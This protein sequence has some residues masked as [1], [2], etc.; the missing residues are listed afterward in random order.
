MQAMDSTM[1]RGKHFV[2]AS[3]QLLPESSIIARRV[4]NDRTITSII[5][6]RVQEVVKRHFECEAVSG[7]DLED[8]GGPGSAG[9]H[10]EQ[11]LFEGA[12]SAER[13]KVLPCVLMICD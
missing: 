3:G 7:A 10:W 6:P 13:T 9:S 8:D 11:R 5:T 4:V 1:F 2:D 12:F